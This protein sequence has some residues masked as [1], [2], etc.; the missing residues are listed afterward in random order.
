MDNPTLTISLF[1]LR[2]R[3]ALVKHSYTAAVYSDTLESMGHAIAEEIKH[4]AMHGGFYWSFARYKRNHLKADIQEMTAIML[5]YPYACRAALMA[6]LDECPYVHYVIHAQDEINTKR[7][8]ER[9][10]IAFPLAKPITSPRDYTRIAA[11]LSEQLGIGDHTR[12]DF[13][14]TF[15]FAPFV[16]VCSTPKV[17]LND[18]DREFLDPA[19][20]IEEHRGTWT[21]ARALQLDAVPAQQ[22]PNAF[23]D[24]GLFVFEN[25]GAL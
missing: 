9:L 15:L 7:P 6:A 17:V 4:Q 1:K 23:H 25:G 13:S 20:F 3:R 12:G 5:E 19:E 18:L 8:E 16:G 10:V 21:D 11:L 2:T 24:S 22:L 14:S